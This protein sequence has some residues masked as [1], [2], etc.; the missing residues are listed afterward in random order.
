MAPEPKHR[1]IVVGGLA[2]GLLLL[3][4]LFSALQ[5]L[6]LS[7]LEP[8]SAGLVLLF[9]GLSVVAFLIFVVLLVLLSR[10]ILK[11]YADQRSRVLG[12]RLRSRMLIG[13]LLLSLAPAMFMFFYSYFLL[14]RSIDRWFS[15]PVGQL[16]EDSTRVALELS[17]YATNNAR[18]EAEALAS[19]PTLARAL[20]TDDDPVVIAPTGVN[21]ALIEVLRSRRIT[22]QGGFA[23]VYH[24]GQ[25][26]AQFQMPAQNG[27]VVVRPWMDE[28]ESTMNTSEP[29]TT[30]ILKAAQRSDEPVVQFAGGEFALGAATVGPSDSENN[31]V[32]IG[33]P[34]PAGLSVTV[35]RIRHGAEGT[36]RIRNGFRRLAFSILL[37]LTA[38][39]LFT[40]SW[41]ALFLSKQITRP[42]EA[43]ADAMDEIAAGHY[44]HRVAV[45]ATEE[46]GEL[47]RSFNHMAG[48][49]EESRAIAETSTL[50]LSAANLTSEERRRELE[51]VLE[52]I[53]SGVVTLDSS[54]RVLQANRAF[55]DLLEPAQQAIAVGSSIQSLFPA[56][57]ADDLTRLLRRS[58]RMGIAA[59]EFEFRSPKGMLNLSTTMAALELEGSQRG[60]ILVVED[61]TEFLRA[62]RQVAWKEVA[63]RV[64]HEIKN[65]L[66]PIS[67]SAERIRKHVDRPTPESAGIIR[68]CSEVILGS[69]DTMRTLVD[70]FAALA[71]FPTAQPKPNDLNLIVE[72]ALM[73]F[74]GRLGGITIHRRLAPD[75]PPVMA[76][77][78]ALKRAFANLIDNAAEAMQ[79]SLLRQLTIETCLNDNNMAEIV[80]ADTGHGLTAETRERLFLPYFSTK[81]RGTGLGLSIAAKIVQEHEGA[82]RA[83][84]N[85]PKGARFVMELP[86]AEIPT[87]DGGRNESSLAVHGNGD[88]EISG[89]LGRNG[90]PHKNGNGNGVGPMMTGIE[91]KPS[92]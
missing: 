17:H 10:N 34:M 20:D 13:A 21:L 51:T 53:P 18:V 87:I 61:V 41:L 69:V 11:L 38:L 63:Q 27:R 23:I 85:T 32:V 47:V 4:L 66:T 73:L 71:Q 26:V 33:L 9:T 74:A 3:L 39:I 83:E 44:K 80:V 15:Q 58:Q 25:P 68:K 49:L 72:S 28:S 79:G 59:M 30:T 50:Q 70:Q 16:R 62:Q 82:I 40:S 24:E 54:M 75:I 55:L 56:D 60:C 5:G 86:L 8:R 57:L 77:A 88:G 67:L 90:A 42:V 19:S 2:A 89:N 84:Q 43:L 78:E 7:F 45:E 91:A 37:L 29:A 22:L 31:V 92:R 12:S 36:Y 64:A 1:K 81:Q 52:T 46:L 14:N 35:A 48:D 6:N 65:P 76:D